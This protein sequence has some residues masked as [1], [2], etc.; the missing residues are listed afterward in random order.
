MLDQLSEIARNLP[1][2][3]GSISTL[4]NLQ[5][6]LMKFVLAGL[7]NTEHRKFC[8]ATRPTYDAQAAFSLFATDREDA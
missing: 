2:A 1:L 4:T 6:H 7:G 3:V 8:L 5:A